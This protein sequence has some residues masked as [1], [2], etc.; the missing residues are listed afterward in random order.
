MARTKSKNPDAMTKVEFRPG[1][2]FGSHLDE[3]A[4][5]SG[6]TRGE[7]AKRM[8][9]LGYLGLSMDHYSDI[10]TLA[11]RRGGE[12]SFWFVA[13]N[14]AGPEY[15]PDNKEVAERLAQ[16]KQ[17]QQARI[18]SAKRIERLVS[19]PAALASK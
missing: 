9:I 4:S 18:A 19:K 13:V 14:A 2:A 1:E 5:K 10:A 7:V 8:C 3:I 16:M 12:H 15:P 6:L 17:D 11:H